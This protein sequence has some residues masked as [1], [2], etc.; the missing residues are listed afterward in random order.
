MNLLLAFIALELTLCL[1]PGPAVLLT[2][3]FGSSTV[4][5]GRVRHAAVDASVMRGGRPAIDLLG[6]E[7]PAYRT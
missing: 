7:R 4:V 1:I 6:K 3:S 5:F 2:V